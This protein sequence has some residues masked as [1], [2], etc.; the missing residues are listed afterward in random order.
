MSKNQCKNDD[1]IQNKL[2]CKRSKILLLKLQASS[3]F[4]KAWTNFPMQSSS[5][6]TD[7]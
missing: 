7:T 4:S 6:E 2:L 1:F 5:Y 3:S